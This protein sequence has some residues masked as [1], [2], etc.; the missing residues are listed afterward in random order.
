MSAAGRWHAAIITG[1]VAD[2]DVF[3]AQWHDAPDAT[4]LDLTARH[5]IAVIL[6]GGALSGHSFFIYDN[7]SDPA[8]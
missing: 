3:Y 1:L 4:D 7:V 6:D 2:H 8:G 5:A